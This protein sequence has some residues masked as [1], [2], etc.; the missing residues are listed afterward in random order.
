MSKND[1]WIAFCGPRIYCIKE[2][3]MRPSQMK[4]DTAGLNGTHYMYRDKRGNSTVPINL[5]QLFYCVDPLSLRPTPS[6]TNVARTAG[7]LWIVLVPQS[8]HT[9]TH[10]ETQLR[11]EEG[12][13]GTLVSPIFQP[14]ANAALLWNVPK[15][16]WNS[17]L[18]CPSSKLTITA[19]ELPEFAFVFIVQQNGTCFNVG[20]ERVALGVL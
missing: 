16:L 2:L 9:Y 11:S 12:T 20:F 7:C 17:L 18:C 14:K 15:M 10:R 6:D 19:Q 4:V 8:S 3:V 5:M 1:S 13:E